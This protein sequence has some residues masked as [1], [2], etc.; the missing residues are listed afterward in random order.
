MALKLYEETVAHEN[1][2]YGLVDEDDND[3][4]AEDIVAP[5]SESSSSQQPSTMQCPCCKKHALVHS[6]HAY[7][8]PCG[9]KIRN[10]GT[11]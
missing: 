4:L 9:V 6:P 2:M 10:V 5:S 11:I 7:L 8:C 1:E 3:E